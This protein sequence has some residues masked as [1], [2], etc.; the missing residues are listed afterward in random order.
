MIGV[1]ALRGGNVDR[2][3]GYRLAATW[4]PGL[5]ESWPY[6]VRVDFDFRCEKS[7]LD[8]AVGVCWRGG[9]APRSAGSGP[10]KCRRV[11]FQVLKSCSSS[12]KS[13]AKREKCISNLGD[14]ESS[15]ASKDSEST[16]TSRSTSVQSENGAPVMWSKPVKSRVGDDAGSRFWVMLAG[17]SD[18]DEAGA[19]CVKVRNFAG[20]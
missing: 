15:S 6:C 2:Q 17:K 1:K 3:I 14:T 12:G 5:D 9:K 7:H 13:A 19:L 11:T 10:G 16:S 8:D 18:L 4:A 20:P